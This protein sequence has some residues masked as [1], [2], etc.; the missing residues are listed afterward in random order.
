MPLVSKTFWLIMRPTIRDVAKKLNLSITT[1]SRALDGYDDVATQTKER[2]IK[3]AND[4]GYVPNR[5]ARQL[6]KQKADTIGFIIPSIS[7]RFDEPFFAE[8][9]AGLGEELSSRDF[10]LLVANAT[11]DDGEEKLYN[12]WIQSQ[13]VDGVILNRIRKHDWR[14]NYL[15]RW[16]LPFVALGK[17]QDAV[18][19]PCIR[20]DGT[21][22]YLDLVQHVQL[23][24]FSRF[25]FIGGPKDIIDH[26]DRLKWFKDALMK[27]GLQ[28]DSENVLSTDMSSTEGYEAAQTIL[29]R[30]S[31]PDAIFCVN[32]ET[33]FGVLHAAHEHGFHIGRDIAVVG[34]DGVQDAK[35]S[36]PPLSTLDIPIFDIA[37]KL[38]EMLLKSLDGEEIVTPV[39]IKPTLLVRQS[40]GS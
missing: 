26:I 27:C 19:Y 33:A 36:E 11:T 16:N 13:K 15:S 28:M 30:S 38:V 4:M 29:S 17:S 37:R 3:T 2:V 20:L 23:N 18:D 35:H 6:R 21:Q 32:D 34:F 12:R 25:A 1:I 5:A 22:V 40:T 8:F 39:F 31:P 7:K 10:D 14:V 9:I 24:G